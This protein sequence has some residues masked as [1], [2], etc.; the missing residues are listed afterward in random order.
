MAEL[1]SSR[2]VSAVDED[3]FYRFM[4][5]CPDGLMNIMKDY[6]EEFKDLIDDAIQYPI[7]A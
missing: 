7:K 2:L 1:L 6:M 3:K 4:Q 5:K